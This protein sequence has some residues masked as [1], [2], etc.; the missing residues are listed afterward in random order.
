M[1]KSYYFLNRYNIELREI[2][3][4]KTILEIFSQ[5]KDKLIIHLK[6]EEDNFIEFNVSSK[7]PYILLKRKFNR[8][9]KNTIDFFHPFIGSLVLDLS[10]AS[11]D[12]IIKITTS[13]GNIF[14]TI[15]GNL[16]NVFYIAD[17]QIY[18]FKKEDDI[19]LA[20]LKSDFINKIYISSFNMI[21]ENNL[22]GKSL[23]QIK[24]EFPFI[25]KD[26]L[27]EVK[28]RQDDNSALYKLI[29][30]IL[31]TIRD[32]KPAVFFNDSSYDL[33]LGFSNLKIFAGM[34][35]DIYDDVVTALN[36]YVSKKY[37]FSDYT[38]KKTKIELYLKRELLK[39]TERLNNLR[40][41]IEKGSKEEL[42]NK[43]ANLLLINLNKILP[44][45]DEVE[46]DD[47]YDNN[48]SIKIK[49]DPKLNAHKNIDR[50]FEKS[51]DE[52]INFEKSVQLKEEAEKYFQ[53][54][55]AI[56]KKLES[57][58][59][60]KELEEIMSELKIK[61]SDSSKEENDISSKFKHY[62]IENKY[63]VYVGKDSANND[64]LTTKFAKQNDFWF[65]A[66]SVSGSH[67]V[68]R[69]ENTKE[70]IPKNILKKAAALA[71]YHSK[72]KTSGLASVSYTLKKYVVKR[73]G[74]PLGQVSLLN[75][76]VLLVKP[77]IPIDCE[78]I[79]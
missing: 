55:K 9:K 44:G 69:V 50:Y 40:A 46:I 5:E 36:A 18:G 35:K 79:S 3:I 63:N 48:K 76:K 4:N 56:E 20:Q 78:F 13:V 14:F 61:E 31:I 58:Q 41:V 19:K 38:S 54:L 10:I 15:R 47:I 28:L 53:K 21:D 2:L 27:N 71:A 45:I 51:R 6:N 73:K 16:T 24:K 25:G 67:V 1:Y 75:E 37:F 64:L 7:E 52:K 65:H 29:N 77:E 59:T 32:D 26:I 43:Y 22:A 60:I 66:R 34:R 49:L 33:K 72:A 11:D 39:V 12:R 74:M 23:E 8:A 42:Y 68:L 70:V 57:T 30:D 62:I 17:D